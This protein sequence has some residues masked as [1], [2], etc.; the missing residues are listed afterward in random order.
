MSTTHAQAAVAAELR[1]A[2]YVPLPRLW[3]KRNEIPQVHTIATKH[4]KFVSKIRDKHR[5][6]NVPPV[7]L[8][9]SDPVTDKDAAWAL[10]ENK[11]QPK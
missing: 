2:G 3:V 6:K 8:N 4:S 1:E 11:G 9:L 5:N 7:K 10:F